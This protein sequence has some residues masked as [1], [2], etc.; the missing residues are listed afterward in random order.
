[1]KS[2]TAIVKKLEEEVRASKLANKFL[3]KDPIA[4]INAPAVIIE[5]IVQ[6]AASDCGIDMDWCFCAG[7]GF[8]FA[9]GDKKLA[10]RALY[11][12]MPNSDLTT[13]DL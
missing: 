5:A 9:D 13:S 4:N 10:R 11:L 12:A 7:R 3:N 2:T 8:I 6:K 1:M